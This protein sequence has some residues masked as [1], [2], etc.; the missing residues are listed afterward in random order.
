MVRR[1]LLFLL[2]LL[3]LGGCLQSPPPVA[4][5]PQ[6]APAEIFVDT[7]WHGTVIIDGQVKVYKGATLTIA[8]G[9]EI[10]F[11]RQDRDQDG[12]GDGTL[13]VEGALVAVG[14]RQ[15]PIRFRSAASDPQ[16]G[17]WLEL[18]VD[19]ARDCRLS[20]CE[21]RDSAHTLHAHFTRA[22]VEDCT[23]RYNIDGCRLGQGNFAIRRCLIE[24]NSGKGIN[25]RNST[26]EIS[27]N[28]IRRNG[29]G[30]FLF[31]TDRALLIA[32][33]NF[34]G[35]GHNLRLG[36][37][38]Q[39]DI[40]VGRNW[41]GFADAQGAAATVYDRKSDVTLGTVTIDVAP[42]WLAATGP[43][44]GVILTSAWDLATGG[45]VDATAVAWER[46]F[47]LPGWDGVV[48]ALFGDSQLL[49]QRSLG[50]TID[51][52]PAVD[53][54]RL[55]LQTWGREVVALDRTDGSVRWRF[56]YPA[57]PADDHRQG[58]LLRLDDAILVPGWNGTLYAL[59]PASGKLLWSFTA[60]A[61]LRATPVSDGQRI[62][63]SGGDGTMWALD[64][65]GRLLWERSL[66]APLLS[67]PVLLPA[68]VAVLSRSGT[69]VALS[70]DGQE[71]WRRSL[72][73]ECWYGAPVYDRDTLFVVT[74]AGSLWR[75][76]ADSGRTVW[77]RDGLGP[78]YAT[79]LVADGRV[80]VG[81]NA[82]TFRVYG[83]D[84]AELLASFTVGAPLQGTPLLQGG[85]LIF[86]AR[87]QRIHALDMLP[88]DE[89][90]KNP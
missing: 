26:V 10:L 69:L 89:K 55:Y 88:S 32:G 22:V 48:R 30:I 11:V 27:G 52:T 57:S 71:L 8:P 4:G 41:W 19:F 28:I 73:Q 53:A 86:G 75:R 2:P 61:P 43:R 50:E 67:S 65:N 21:I 34:H 72:Q 81:D 1:L 12:L 36:D 24:D 25:F 74:A 77:R 46:V 70:A 78:V 14:S 42:E 62:Y 59:H 40:T 17:D 68:G 16:P 58:G 90:T 29:T 6:T 18:R 35:N 31:E 56:S 20:F 33:N 23:I 64:L 85:R 44:D 45:F 15:Q 54:E 3:C 49:W 37:F 76:D 60:R 38:F 79:P 83:G 47:Y 63:L 5:R 87:D 13:I 39:H 7:V 9:T 51:A 80:M 84:S 82:G 66:D